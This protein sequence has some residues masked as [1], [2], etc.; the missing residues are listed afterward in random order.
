MSE[1]LAAA[2]P[3]FFGK[4]SF[5][6]FI[7]VV[8]DVNDPTHSG[9]VKIRCI[10]WHPRDRDSGSEDSLKTEDLPWAR[11]GMP[12]THAQ[13]SR[14]G[15]KH[16]LVP[17]CCVFGCFLDGDE[18]QDPFVLASFSATSNASDK[19][20]RT[21]EAGDTGTLKEGTP[22]FAKVNASANTRNTGRQ[23][24]DEQQQK[25]YSNKT[26]KAGDNVTDDSDFEC[27]GDQ[28][29]MNA[30][31][32]ASKGEYKN[33]ENPEGQY[34][35]ITIADG[36]CGSNAHSSEDVQLKLQERLPAELSRFKYGDL[37]W[38]RFQGNFMDLNGI[39]AQV[40]IEVCSLLKQLVQ[41]KKSEQ[42]EKQFRE[43]DGEAY[44]AE[45]GRNPK[46][47]LDKREE[48]RRESDLYNVGV[49]S[50]V[51]QLCMI[52]MALLQQQ[53]NGGK[54]ERDNN[55]RSRD[56][57]QVQITVVP[58]A[59]ANT[60]I[61]DPSAP[62]VGETFMN[63]FILTID[64]G[65]DEA[66]IASRL[67]LQ[68]AI[69]AEKDE[70]NEA[71]G[72]NG[73]S[74]DK[75][76]TGLLGII[77]VVAGS[78]MIFPLIDKY[79]LSNVHNT[80][81]D[82]TQ[83]EA[84]RD[85]CAQTRQYNTGFGGT[86]AAGF[87]SAMVG[88]A[89]SAA[90]GVTALTDGSG[91]RSGNSKQS[92]SVSFPNRKTD[93]D[94][95]RLAWL[96]GN[97]GGMNVSLGTEVDFI[98]CEDG[99]IV[100]FPGR[101]DITGVTTSGPVFGDSGVR[102]VSESTPIIPGFNTK[103]VGRNVAATGLS[104]PSGDEQGATNFRDGTPNVVAVIN[105]G[106]DYYYP[107]IIDKGRHYPSIYIPG[108]N[109]TPIPVVDRPTGELVAVITNAASFDPNY[110]MAPVT[111][112]PDDSD[113]GIASDDPNYDIV[114]VDFFV[115]NTGFQYCNPEIVIRDKDT[116]KENGKVS[117]VVVEGRI[118][119]VNIEDSGSGFRRVPTV[120][121]SDDGTKCGTRGGFGAK[122]YPIMAVI[123]KADSKEVRFPAD[124]EFFVFCPAKN[125][126]NILPVTRDPVEVTQQIVRDA[127]PVVPSPTP[128]PVPSPTP[129]PTPT[130]YV[131]P[132]P[133]PTPTPT[134]VTP[135]PSPTPPTPSPTPTPTPTPTPSPTPTPPSPTPPYGGGYY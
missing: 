96:Q 106:K 30:S 118:V 70:D 94:G 11:V 126:V 125:K 25:G 50:I 37:V 3:D 92:R 99:T 61:F 87:I 93:P 110:P 102:V 60:T 80:A 86:G 74:L 115:Q 6:P 76:V 132:A 89:Q 10:G 108:Y 2:R 66:A 52:I 42:E 20:N 103:P 71:E 47:R 59:N 127:M 133:V 18:A 75:V 129:V 7:G 128:A 49:A 135:T 54:E 23:T 51:D 77:S 130:P 95:L 78:G 21:N 5:T 14:I 84:T 105:P 36:R 101:S 28:A 97:V 15:G 134:P 73:S 43:K 114:I 107:N 16:G 55:N 13:S 69:T 29:R 112:R 48:K 68:A 117:V 4:D 64:A 12:T 113:V 45:P 35:N 1:P 39:L 123:P 111:I 27:Y 46:P 41:S 91:G 119:D 124:P 109:G 81:G 122:I 104:L 32:A 82:K 57:T 44:S 85:G 8:E 63:N 65:I 67:T 58:G 62:C 17:G 40:S 33:P 90:E 98:T 72:E 121:I 19:D 34:C 100:K 88:A 9:R 116:E 79:A 24:A 26:D 38:E 22:G 131:P 31:S 120:E 53:Q 56:N 83:D